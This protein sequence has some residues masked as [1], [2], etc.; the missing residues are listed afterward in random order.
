[1]I[2]SPHLLF[3]KTLSVFVSKNS[4]VP[5][6]QSRVDSASLIGLGVNCSGSKSAIRPLLS[7]VYKLSDANPR[8]HSVFEICAQ[9]H[10]KTQR[11]N[12]IS[13]GIFFLYKKLV[14][15]LSSGS[16]T[17]N[18]IHISKKTRSFAMHASKHFAFFNA[19]DRWF[20]FGL[21]GGEGD[22]RSCECAYAYYCQ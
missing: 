16:V 20:C 9:E 17:V 22:S 19:V 6:S 13:L 21:C 7:N 2:L 5:S 4:K 1:M 3:R 18:T 11:K 10:K 12:T 14:A 8:A 15:S